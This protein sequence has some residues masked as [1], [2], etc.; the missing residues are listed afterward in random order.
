MSDVSTNTLDPV[1]FIS[2]E[3][4]LSC[5]AFAPDSAVLV[6]GNDQGTVDVYQLTGSLAES[7]GRTTMQQIAALDKVTSTVHEASS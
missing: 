4:R 2:S 5:V 1:T 6:A 3:R 7:T